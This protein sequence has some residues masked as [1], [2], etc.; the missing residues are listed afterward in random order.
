MK[1]WISQSVST[2]RNGQIN[3]LDWLVEQPNGRITVVEK[4]KSRLNGVSR[5]SSRCSLRDQCCI[6][7]LGEYSDK[8]MER[9]YKG[10][11]RREGKGMASCLLTLPKGTHVRRLYSPATIQLHNSPRY[12]RAPV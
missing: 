6:R 2:E 3:R 12:G 11:K 7:G 9:R 10:L 5:E 1:E 8:R 4:S